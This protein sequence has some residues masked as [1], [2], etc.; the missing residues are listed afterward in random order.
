M[1]SEFKR[2]KRCCRG[3]AALEF[4]MTVPLLITCCVG[5]ADFGLALR[6]QMQLNQAVSDGASY[7]FAAQQSMAAQNRV[8]PAQVVAVTSADL[9]LAN[10][11][12]TAT[13]P[14]PFCTQKNSQSASP[15][16]SLIAGSYDTSC[17][18][19]NPAGTY[20]TITA[21]QTYTPLTPAYTWLA[22]TVLSASVIVRLY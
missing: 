20:M 12:V 1:K 13:T 6:N 21:Q 5:M 9:S 22:Q 19:G 8:T 3:L 17:A 15:T 18:N 11:Q 4:A 7:A 16:T 14:G 2:L 10:V